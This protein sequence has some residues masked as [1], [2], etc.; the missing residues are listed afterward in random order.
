MHFSLLDIIS[1]S[2]VSSEPLSL[3]PYTHVSPSVVSCL[4]VLLLF[5]CSFFLPYHHV[6]PSCP[7]FLS[8]SFQL[9][10]G[11]G[12][13]N[14]GFLFTL[15]RILSLSSFCFCLPLSLFG[16]SPTVTF[17]SCGLCSISPLFFHFT[18]IPCLLLSLDTQSVSFSS[19]SFL[20][21]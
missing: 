20:F 14:D 5:V 12:P 2:A 6:L 19:L 16:K 21:S 3:S 1:F 4:P 8:S 10:A 7:S 18:F 17:S 11:A 15:F 9:L 13:C